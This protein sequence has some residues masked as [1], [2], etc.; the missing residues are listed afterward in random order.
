MAY[1][2]GFGKKDHGGRDL[3]K[4]ITYPHLEEIMAWDQ[5]KFYSNGNKNYGL[6]LLLVNYFVLMD[7]DGDKVGENFKKCIQAC[8]DGKS[9]AEARQVLLAGRTY[10]QLEKD[11]ASAMRKKGIKITY[12]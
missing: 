7:G 9:E 1:A 6:G 2:T 8:Q 11:F 4:D 12:E 10:D 3:G 5:P